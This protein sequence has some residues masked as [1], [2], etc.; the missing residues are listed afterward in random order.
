MLNTFTNPIALFSGSNVHVLHADGT[1]V[2]LTETIH[3]F[4]QGYFSRHGS[5][6]L[7]ETFVA[8]RMNPLEVQLP[9]HVLV[10]I[11]SVKSYVE[12]G[13]ESII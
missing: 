3:H 5:Q 2:R 6:I 7:Q 12:S 10:W 13:G 8:S 11:K 4:A 1:T 9:V